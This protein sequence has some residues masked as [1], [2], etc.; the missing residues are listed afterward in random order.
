MVRTNGSELAVEESLASCIPDGWTAR[1]LQIEIFSQV[2]EGL[3][4]GS[5]YFFLNAPTGSGKSLINLT[6]SRFF[7]TS[8]LMTPLK[9]LQAQYV[10]DF[11]HLLVELKGRSN[12]VCPDGEA[13]NHGG[14]VK[15]GLAP[16]AYFKDHC[17]TCPWLEI[18]DQA[19]RS[20]ITLFNFYSFICQTCFAKRFTDERGCLIIDEAHNLVDTLRSVFD[21]IIQSDSL[22]GRAIG[23][24]TDLGTVEELVTWS[25]IEGISK[26]EKLA[27]LAPEDDDS[28]IF[29]DLLFRLTQLSD[30]PENYVMAND[31]GKYVVR[32]RSVEK[33][34]QTEISPHGKV[35]IFSSATLF[36]PDQ[37]CSY[38]GIDPEK[39]SYISVPWPIPEDQGPISTQL[40]TH[41]ITY[42]SLQ[43]PKTLKALGESVDLILSQLHPGDRG[44]IHCVSHHLGESI[45]NFLSPDSVERLTTNLDEFKQMDG[46]VLIGPSFFEGLDLVGDLCRFQI[47]L[48]IPLPSIKDPLVKTLGYEHP[49]VKRQVVTN[50]AQAYGRGIRSSEDYCTF[51]ILDRM[52]GKWR[53][54]LPD[55]MKRAFI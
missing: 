14:C 22:E 18:L 4:R 42:R 51:Y 45:T 17:G 25:R 8:Y 49:E 20:P 28:N 16:G 52:V 2:E 15:S 37:I 34:F 19:N 35:K 46:L 11:G 53:E 33:F 9:N 6:L 23:M 1:D 24:P 12:Y 47:L 36:D 55:Y 5:E 48:K 10:D 7:G 29:R 43:Q 38:L 44:V 32:R 41:N 40:A 30:D 21:I 54:A 31:G 27:S 26:A 39:M 13:C 3:S 50:I